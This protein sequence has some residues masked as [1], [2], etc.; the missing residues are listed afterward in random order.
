MPDRHSLVMLVGDPKNYVP[1]PE[2]SIAVARLKGFVDFTF[3]PT[4]EAAK[5][6]SYDKCVCD[7]KLRTVVFDE[8]IRAGGES[9]ILHVLGET[10][11]PKPVV[12]VLPHHKYKTIKWAERRPEVLV[13]DA[14]SW[15]KRLAYEPSKDRGQRQTDTIHNPT[16]DAFAVFMAEWAAKLRKVV[17]R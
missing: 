12:K 9:Y 11:R 15:T 13:D 2:M 4:V 8:V 5:Q 16:L 7:D 10:P 14:D 3:Y 1:Q 6:A 17:S